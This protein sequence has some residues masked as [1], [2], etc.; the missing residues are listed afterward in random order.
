[1]TVVGARS[2]SANL[3]VI[4][5]RSG[6]TFHFPGRSGRGLIGLAARFDEGAAG[7]QPLFSYDFDLNVQP[8]LVIR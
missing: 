4:A 3:I 1:M 2:R 7:S 6:F 8:V 5:R